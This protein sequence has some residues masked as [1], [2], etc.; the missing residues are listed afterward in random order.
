MLFLHVTATMHP[1][2]ADGQVR[3]DAAI[4]TGIPHLTC[5]DSPLQQTRTSVNQLWMPPN[6]PRAKAMCSSGWT[7]LPTCS[8]LIYPKTC[9]A[10]WVSVGLSCNAAGPADTFTDTPSTRAR[11]DA[12][13]DP[14]DRLGVG[15][16]GEK[17]RARMELPKG[18]RARPK[19]AA[20]GAWLTVTTPAPAQPG[21]RAGQA[22]QPDESRSSPGMVGA[23]VDTSARAPVFI[24]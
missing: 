15:G 16:P 11:D 12:E 4:D 8:E 23:V 18:V 20:R 5:V 13:S 1:A 7:I 9:P 21:A 3:A 10:T 19:C 2:A 24:P 6:S 17:V 14:G 22:C